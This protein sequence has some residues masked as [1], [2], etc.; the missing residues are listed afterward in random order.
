MDNAAPLPDNGLTP[1]LEAM[2][3]EAQRAN[4]L[5]AAILRSNKVGRTHRKWTGV[6]PHIWDGTIQIWSGA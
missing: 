3:A 2:I 5:G 1:E 4:G 6:A